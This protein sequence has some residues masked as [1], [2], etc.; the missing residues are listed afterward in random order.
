VGRRGVHFGEAQMPADPDELIMH[1]PAIEAMMEGS[2]WDSR[3]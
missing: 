1:R 3:R 2:Y